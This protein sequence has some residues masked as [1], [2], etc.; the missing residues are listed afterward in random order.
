MAAL[1]EATFAAHVWAPLEA[2][3]GAQPEPRMRL[4]RTVLVG[5]ERDGVIVPHG[6]YDHTTMARATRRDWRSSP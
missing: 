4:Y 2:A 5:P 6:R 1:S 3:F